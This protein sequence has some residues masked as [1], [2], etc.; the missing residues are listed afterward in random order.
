MESVQEKTRKRLRRPFH[1]E[2]GNCLACGKFSV[3][4]GHSA[5]LRVPSE[6]GTGGIIMGGMSVSWCPHCKTAEWCDTGRGLSLEPKTRGEWESAPLDPTKEALAALRVH[7]LSV[8]FLGAPP[9]YVVPGGL[10]G[11]ELVK[12]G[13]TFQLLDVEGQSVH[14]RDVEFGAGRHPRSVEFTL[15]LSDGSETRVVTESAHTI[16]AL[17]EAYRHRRPFTATGP[18]LVRAAYLN[19]HYGYLSALQEGSV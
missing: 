19:G 15:I 2:S 1:I 4:L 12:Y 7:C 10:P 5:P 9:A 8:R 16:R 17:A 14:V 18:Y 11:G 13:R 3:R 6:T